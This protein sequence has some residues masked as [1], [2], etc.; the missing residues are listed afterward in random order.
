MDKRRKTD[1]A[2][3]TSRKGKVKWI[4]RK[5]SEWTRGKKE[6]KG[7]LWPYADR[8]LLRP[9]INNHQCHSPI[10]SLTEMWKMDS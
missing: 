10:I 9:T 4:N 7:V 8:Q 3:K 1:K 6:G 2:N 5:G